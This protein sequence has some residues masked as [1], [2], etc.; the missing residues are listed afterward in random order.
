MI[1]DTSSS[2]GFYGSGVGSDIDP[3]DLKLINIGLDR[4]SPESEIATDF[5]SGSQFDFSDLLGIG[6]LIPS[7]DS[8]QTTASVSDIAPVD[9]PNDYEDTD[10]QDVTYTT[11]QAPTTG[12]TAAPTSG[13]TNVPT[14]TS[15][16]N[17]ITTPCNCTDGEKP[18]TMSAEY[19]KSW[20]AQ[21]ARSSRVWGTG[22][23]VLFIYLAYRAGKNG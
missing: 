15:T 3:L 11:A 18:D 22:I 17:C 14:N 20:M 8:V 7:L 12:Q 19:W 21:Q 16:C 2:L 9:A 6:Y 4:L 5:I 23:L 10:Y 1:L 13:T